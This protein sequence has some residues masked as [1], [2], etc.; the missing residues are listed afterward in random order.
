MVVQCWAGRQWYA[1]PVSSRVATCHRVE[2]IFI[3][4]LP[5]V[6]GCRLPKRQMHFWRSEIASIAFR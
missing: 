2:S 3:C 4:S 6:L 5:V 1:L